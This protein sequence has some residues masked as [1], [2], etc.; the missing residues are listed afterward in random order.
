MIWRSS[1]SRPLTKAGIAA[2]PPTV[3][4]VDLVV[5]VV[6]NLDGDGDVDGDDLP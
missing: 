4:V 3:V 1:A 6:V 2:K 5:D